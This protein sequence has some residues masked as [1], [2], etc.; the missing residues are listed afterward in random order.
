MR[1]LLVVMAM[2][3]ALAVPRPVAA[4]GF[5]AHRYI[6]DRVIQLLPP[7][8]RPFFDK[9]RV[10][11]VEHSIDPDLWRNA[12]WEA[13]PPRHYLDMDAYGPYP[14]KE[15][16]RD[17]DEAVRRYGKD[18]VEKNG[19]LP[20]R[21]GEMHGKLVEAFSLKTPY[22]RD[23]IKFFS[24]VVSH[25]LADAHVPFHATM[26]HD[27]QLTGQWGI[28]ARFESDLFERYAPRLRVSPPPAGDV[29]SVRDLTFDS[30]TAS[31]AY[32]QPIL[33]ADKAAIDGRQVYDDEY[34]SMFF[35]RVRP[36]LE[37]RLA[38]SITDIAS[39]IRSAWIEAG[40]LPLPAQQTRTPRKVRRQ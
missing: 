15:L 5:E 9:Y 35:A 37:K 30:L 12:G 27:G 19:L 10:T 24:S 14:F 29:A 40:R 39:A 23:N 22:A 31:Y 34:Y 11:I 17:Y 36:I 38:D 2:L 21:A 8:L 33:D 7:E 18:F 32:V 16:P 13:E 1:T 25:Y 6:T 26:N 28:H 3:V 4:W 20:W